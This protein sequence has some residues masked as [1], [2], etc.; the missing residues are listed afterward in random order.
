MINRKNLMTLLVFVPF[1]MVAMA[2]KPQSVE[3]GGFDFTPTLKVSEF[4]DDNFRTL[5]D[6]EEA[7][8]ITSVRPTFVLETQTRTSGYQ[9][10]Y[11]VDS[12]TYQDHSAADHVDQAL[13]ARSVMELDARNRLN[14]ELGYKRAEDTVQTAEPRENDKYTLKNGKVGYIYGAR[15]AMNQLEVSAEYQE[16]RYRNSGTLNDDK[17]HDTKTYIGTWYHRL[18]GQTRTLVELRHSD[19]DYVLSDSPR[20]STGD[21]ALVGVTRDITAKLSGSVRVGYE[22]KNFDNNDVNDYSSPTWEANVEYKPRTYSTFSIKASKA[23]E[24]GDDGANTVHD[25]STRLGW[26]HTWTPWVATDVHYRYA[27]LEYLGVG[28]RD[29]KLNDYG[30]SVIYS[31]TRWAEVS[32]GYQRWKNDSDLSDQTYTRNVYMLTVA[33]SL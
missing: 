11:A 33:L 14:W 19:F 24:E 15:T 2:G 5:P 8:W 3:L 23:F 18:G 21:A 9:L 29:D 12:R 16:L 22:R 28:G 10:E 6:H 26:R 25:T 1:P 32:L 30:A 31:P 13:T 7:S 4:Y 17:E 27:D 20:N